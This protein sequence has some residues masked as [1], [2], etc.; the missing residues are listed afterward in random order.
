MQIVQETFARGLSTMLASQ[1]RSVCQVSIRS[2][3]QRSYD[4]YVRELPNPTFLT[5]LSLNP[6]SGAAIFQLPLDVTFCAIEL[7]LGTDV[8]QLN[9]IVDGSPVCEYLVQ[10]TAGAGDVVSRKGA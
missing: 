8:V 7:L 6:L 9:R 1:L 2:I 10:A 4:E 3:D 5:L